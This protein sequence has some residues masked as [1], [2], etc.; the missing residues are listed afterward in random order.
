MLQSKHPDTSTGMYQV[1]LSCRYAILTKD[2]AYRDIGCSL[3]LSGNKKFKFGFSFR[4]KSSIYTKIGI[5]H[6]KSVEGAYFY[7][8][9]PINFL[10]H[11]F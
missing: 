11:Y 1:K 4:L 5:I 7:K 10:S 8:I 9:L 6:Y 2:G 3:T